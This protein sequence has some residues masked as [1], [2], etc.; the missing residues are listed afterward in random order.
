MKLYIKNN[1]N[2]KEENS[3]SLLKKALALYMNEKT[4]SASFDAEDFLIGRTSKGKPYLKEVVKSKKQELQEELQVEKE[5]FS[6]HFSVSHT[7]SMWACAV[8]DCEVGLDIEKGKPGAKFFDIS[9]R[10]FEEAEQSYIEE[11]FNRG[12]EPGIEAFYKV[13]TGREAYA[14]YTGDGFFGPAMKEFSLVINTEMQKDYV[15]KHFLVDELIKDGI[16]VSGEE[17]YGAIC[18]EKDERECWEI[19]QI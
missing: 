12:E 8:C 6:V 19:T 13:W 5:G 17:I 4:A 18:M 9:K 2:S 7:G 11:A 1:Y 10:F 16:V 14:K 3:E 15:I